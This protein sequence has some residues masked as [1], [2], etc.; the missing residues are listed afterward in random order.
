MVIIK[1][2]YEKYKQN[3]DDKNNDDKNKDDD[4]S[5]KC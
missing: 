4:N 5:E 1:K 3:N 2:T